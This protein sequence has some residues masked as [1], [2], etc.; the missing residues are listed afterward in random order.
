VN[1][2]HPVSSTHPAASESPIILASGSPRR[3]R[4]LELI[5]LPIEIVPS[6]I[7]ERPK[8]GEGPS[9]FALRAAREKALDVAS[10]HH[11]RRVLGADTVVEIDGVILGKPAGAKGAREMLRSLSGREHL[12]HTGVALVVADGVR[13]LVDTASVRFAA[14]DDDIISWYVE[15]GEPMDKA[16][17]Y[18]IQG[19][20]GLL[21]V[22]IRGAPHTVV[23]LPIHR[24]PELFTAQGLEFWEVLSPERREEI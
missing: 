17:A 1:Q 23:G 21:V 16:G 22:E 4:L 15:S 7:D 18:A 13:E 5:G 6:G 11:G 12:V 24:L 2:Q 14:L 9:D 19:I 3:K 20:G 8:D 10:R